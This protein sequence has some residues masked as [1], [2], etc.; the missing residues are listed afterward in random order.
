MKAG[1]FIGILL[2]LSLL[3]NVYLLSLTAPLP[4]GV[5]T[6]GR[7]IVEL[8][9]EKAALQRDLADARDT[10]GQLQGEL[11]RIRQELADLRAAPLLPAPSGSAT[12]QA[13]AVAQRIEVVGEFPFAYRRVVEEGSMMNITAEVVA[14]RG[15]V[16]VRTVPLMGIVFQDAANTAVTVARDRTG[17]NLSASDFIFSIE[18]PG[19]VP[20]VDGPSA[21]ALMCLLA[22]ADLRG[23]RLDPRVTLTGTIEE[24]GRIGAIGGVLEKAQAAKAAGKTLF[25]LPE[26]NRVLVRYVERER[27]VG[28]FTFI[29]RVPEEIDTAAY[30]QREVGMPVQYVSTIDDVVRLASAG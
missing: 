20:A 7:R 3:A 29:D 28:A 18:A 8:E 26:G 25:L 15:R 17:A 4:E 11:E 13:P 12:L 1:R 2:V 24:D 30:L 14:G 6:P 23:L 16:L 22:I 19:E 10:T 27:Q 9:Q 5:L 21:G